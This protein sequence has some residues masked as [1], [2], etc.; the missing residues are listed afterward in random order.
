MLWFPGGRLALA[1]LL[2]SRPA[3]VASHGAGVPFGEGRLHRC[4]ASRAFTREFA[5]SPDGC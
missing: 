1:F 4:I 3:L 5:V 2:R